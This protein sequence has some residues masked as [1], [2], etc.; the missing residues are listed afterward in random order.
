MWVLAGVFNYVEVDSAVCTVA[1][2]QLLSFL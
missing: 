1:W 2:H